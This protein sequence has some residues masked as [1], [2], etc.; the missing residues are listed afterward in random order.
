MNRRGM[1]L[2]IALALLAPAISA[3]DSNGSNLPSAPSASR[4]QQAHPAPKR[5]DIRELKTIDQMA[6]E[7]QSARPPT[8]SAQP[9]VP[10]KAEENKP[11]PPA[12][13][14]PATEDK[15]SSEEK[16]AASAAAG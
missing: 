11:T 9:A 12:D 4:Q 1:L 7:E 13:N 3:Q 2:G 16:P 6:Q 8:G 14:S 5:G 10:A 15:N